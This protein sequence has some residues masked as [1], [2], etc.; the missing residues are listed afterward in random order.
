MENLQTKISL[1][2]SLFKG[3]ED[4]FATRWE[5]DKKSGYMPAYFFD[6]YR[7][8]AHKMK[9]GTFQNYPD[10]SPVTYSFQATLRPYQQESMGVISKKDIGVIVVLPGSGK[11]VM[12]LK[13]VAE[14]QQPALIIVHRKQLTM[15]WMERIEAFLGIV[16]KDIG[17]IGQGK[18]KIGKQSAKYS[19]PFS[20][21]PFFL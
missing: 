3:R 6:P 10:N 20:G 1:F 2:R 19:M 17:H 8:R 16:Q 11:T 12:A 21:L 13:I 14:K 7:Y 15:Q 18:T 9:G 4:V 5:K